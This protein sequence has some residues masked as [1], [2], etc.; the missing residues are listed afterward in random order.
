MS[1]DAAVLR[2]AGAPLAIERLEIRNLGDDDVL[3]RIMATSLCHTD[4]EAVEGQLGTP[5]PL[6]PGHE[7]AGIVEWVGQSVQGK[8]V[9]DHVVISWNP[10]CRHCFYC[11]KHQPIL[12]QQYRDNAA[13]SM[14]FDGQPR[15]FAHG[16]PVHQLM[17]AGTFSEMV[18]VTAGCA[19]KI[20]VDIPF[21]LACLIG[22]GVMTGVGAALNIAQVESGSSASVIGC[23]AV[24][25]SAI[26]GAKL[27][28]AGT[29]IAI[30]RDPA[31]LETARVFGAT[32]TLLADDALVAAHLALTAGRGADYVFEAAGNQAAFRASMELVRPGGQVVWLGKV[33]VMQDIAF[34]WGSMMGEKKIVRSSYGGTD[35]AKDFPFLVNAWREGRLLLAEYVTSRIRL[36]DVNEGLLRLK[37]GL[38]IRS[39]IRFD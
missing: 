15:F 17:Y 5:L 6:I 19:V 23:G 32:H 22:C 9:G 35:P 3:V 36:A 27:A 14:H 12:C 18:A 39:V 30:D 2:T 26:Q 24:G 16:E 38:E 11:G 25:L 31:K 7:A 33:P 20:P 8:A 34:R 1:F 10:H 21:E 13:V 37:Q 4:L 28:G 29:I